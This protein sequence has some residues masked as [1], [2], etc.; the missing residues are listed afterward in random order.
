MTDVV[1]R[2]MDVVVIG[3]GASG[4][5]A[6]YTAA[7]A[8]LKVMLIEKNSFLGGMATAAYV[9]TICGLYYRST[10]SDFDFVRNGFAK[11]FSDQLA[12]VSASS[13][14][15]G[16]QG[17][18]FLPYQREAFI[19][20]AEKLLLEV[21]VEIRYNSKLNGVSYRDNKIQDIE[22]ISG[23]NTAIVYSKHF[24]D[25]SGFALFTNYINELPSVEGNDYQAGAHVFGLDCL[26]VDNEMQLN[27]H[28][29]KAQKE[30]FLSGKVETD[31]SWISVIPGSLRGNVAY[32][33]LSIPFALAGTEF[34]TNRVEQ[35]TKDRLS[36][37]LTYFRKNYAPLRNVRLSMIAPSVGIRT[38]PRYLGDYTLTEDDV[39]YCKKRS[40]T[41]ARGA[42]P[43]EYWRPGE[44]VAMRYFEFEDY[45]DIPLACL[46]NKIVDN[47]MFGGRHISACEQAI[48]SARVIGTCMQ[49]GESIGLFLARIMSP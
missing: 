38:G 20:L 43:I 44:K 42:W 19:N 16:Q 37:W 18:K 31:K 26:D 25:C 4:I 21:G 11:M 1:T 28:L 15:T 8:G 34:D 41:A 2:D 7:E 12:E 6:A 27:L 47:L 24:V 30:G 36:T 40:D 10:S 22:V 29:I 3:G 14:I 39:L 35:Y 32:F 17:L 23:E 5:A 9:G 49:M 48:A 45:Y 13:P 46:Q 33:K